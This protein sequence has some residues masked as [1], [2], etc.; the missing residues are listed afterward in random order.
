MVHVDQTMK[1]SSKANLL[2]LRVGW[3]MDG[4]GG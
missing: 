3:N 4:W 2:L 1:S